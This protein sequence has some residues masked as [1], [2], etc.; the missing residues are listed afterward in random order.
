MANAA[1]RSFSAGSSRS[2]TSVSAWRA[3][4]CIVTSSGDGVSTSSGATGT[5]TM[6]T[7]DVFTFA[8]AISQSASLVS[9]TYW[10]SM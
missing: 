8:R 10:F 1:N 6:M 5:T 7:S 2:L 3:S 9:R 4:P